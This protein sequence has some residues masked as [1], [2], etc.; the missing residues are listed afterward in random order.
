MKKQN[1]LVVRIY[2]PPLDF[3]PLKWGERLPYRG[4]G[5]QVQVVQKTPLCCL[6]LQVSAHCGE[7]GRLLSL[8]AW[9]QPW[10]TQRGPHLGPPWR[11]GGCRQAFP[12]QGALP[13]R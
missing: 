1:L 12:G 5:Q 9:A 11:A 7:S 3:P 6:N 10:G 2:T 13:D 4:T 8:A